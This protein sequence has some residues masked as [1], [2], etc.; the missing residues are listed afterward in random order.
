[1]FL[2]SKNLPVTVPAAPT[3]AFPSCRLL[4]IPEIFLY[5]MKLVGA[6]RSANLL[7]CCLQKLSGVLTG[8]K[9]SP[10]VSPKSRNACPNNIKRKY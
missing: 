2:R 3:V 7:S 4:H 5:L 9:Q 10:K 1:M 6:S 8:F